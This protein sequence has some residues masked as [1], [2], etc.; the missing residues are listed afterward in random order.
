VRQLPWEG[1]AEAALEAALAEVPVLTRI[2]TAK[3]WRDAAEARARAEGAGAVA[4]AHVA[5]A[6]GR[7]ME[8]A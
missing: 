6:T 4:T 1:A 7:A 2:S 8:T 5:A 3:G